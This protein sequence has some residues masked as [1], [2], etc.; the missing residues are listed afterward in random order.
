MDI[1]RLETLLQRH[2]DQILKPDERRELSRL[3]LESARAREFFWAFARWN[4]LLRQWGEAEWGRRDAEGGLTAMEGGERA[5]EILRSKVGGS[6]APRKSGVRSSRSSKGWRL[7][8]ASG[9]FAAL[10]LVLS[11]SLIWNKEGREPDATRP[12]VALLT[13]A[14]EAQWLNPS[15]AY[16][17]G[18]VLRAGWVR[19]KAGAIQ[20]EF[21][22]GARVILEGPV[23]LQLIS[24]NECRLHSGKLR[25][26]V[27]E[28]AH[29]FL[30]RSNGFD[31]T[32]LGTE[33][34]CSVRP[35]EAS[36]VHVF[37]G[38][39]SLELAG[40]PELGRQLHEK[41]ALWIDQERVREIPVRPD[42]FLS[43]AELAQREQAY[44]KTRMTAWREE[45][46][47]LSRRPSV[48]MYLDF[49]STQ[50]WARSL[51]NLAR[52]GLL[53]SNASIIG[54]EP[55]QGRWPNK[56]ALQFEGPD[57]RLRFSLPG[58]HRSMTLL[59]WVRIDRLEE[60]PTCLLMTEGRLPGEFEWY[61]TGDG[62]LGFGMRLEGDDLGNSWRSHSPRVIGAGNFGS[63][64]LLGAVL[65]G[66]SKTLT[67][68]VNGKPVGLDEF[69]NETAAR[70][71]TVEVGNVGAGRG[72]DREAATQGDV[73]AQGG[74][75]RF[76]GRMD[77]LAILSDPLQATE[78]RQF[79]VK[80]WPGN[81]GSVPGEGDPA[82]HAETV[83]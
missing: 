79:Y 65:D 55:V 47:R 80:G 72:F 3:L 37:D 22:R 9:V 69:E 26:Y 82:F 32:D 6:A 34:G 59:A 41:Q 29:G 49:E 42:G 38:M 14:S 57:D 58:L 71:G 75:Q 33:F 27:P 67:H 53:E 16:L 17:P 8:A 31:V 10:L 7:G 21:I 24:E 62:R 15:D 61:L 20:L 18:Q 25:A 30:V 40:R 78:I 56:G 4:A 1:D 54:C 28:P 77:E 23:E 83:R 70:I 73:I 74:F 5:R 13:R 12:G 46:R 52:R 81:Q 36:E 50:P 43:D 63:W 45:S 48:L 64:I 19:L 39:V 44:A 68:Y 76:Q 35:G 2:F 60:G 51:D 66:A 11:L